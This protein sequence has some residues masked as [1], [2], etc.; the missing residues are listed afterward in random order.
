[1]N[2]NLYSRTNISILCFCIT[3]LVV[4]DIHA[5]NRSY[6]GF[7]NNP[8]NPSWG[9]KGAQ[10]R[11]I[12]PVSYG[13]GISAPN[14]VDRPNPRRISNILFDQEEAIFDNHALTDYVWVFGQFVEHDISFIGRDEAEPLSINV[15]ECDPVFDPNCQGQAIIPMA[16]S[17][18]IAGSGMSETNPRAYA[19]EVSAFLDGSAIYGSDSERA[20]WLRTFKDGKLKTSTGG[21]LPYNTID[22]E[23]NSATDNSAPEMKLNSSG[24]RRWFVAGDIR[25]NENMMLTSMHTLWVREHNR[26]CQVMS[27]RNPAM[28][29][30]ELYQKARKMVGAMIQ[31]ITYGEWLPAM[32]VTLDPYVSYW[33]D[34]DPNVSNVF[35]A[36]ASRFLHTLLSEELLRMDDGCTTIPAGDMSLRESFF[37]PVLVTESGIDPMLKG[38]SA[39]I[40]QALDCKLVD[41]IRNFIIESAESNL[42]CDF[43]AININRGRERG[44]PDYNTVR[45][46]LG[47]GRVRS[48]EEIVEDPVEARQLADLYGTVDNIDPWVGMLAEEHLPGAMFGETIMNIMKGQFKVLRDAD[49][50]F[51][52]NDDGLTQD[53]KDEVSSTRLSDVIRRNTSITALQEN[54]FVMEKHCDI[55]PVDEQHL[56]LAIAPNPVV[57]DYQFSMYSFEEGDGVLRVQNML[58]QLIQEYELPV[59]RGTNTYDL[60]FPDSAPMGIYTLTFKVG[61]ETSTLK[62]SRI[63]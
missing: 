19:N 47:L 60:R 17:R 15:P 36:A 5:Q 42:G 50:F 56:N 52:L 24:A 16:R 29:D 18:A 3:Y 34:I 46:A 63:Y 44:L 10:I 31:Q 27:I 8:S 12:T 58:G 38:M 37:N 32:G 41:D 9:A 35:S 4:F 61:R 43:A 25:A 45:D 59:S 48:F 51:F 6:D 40:Q 54:V 20:S 11:N 28:T 21:F 62:V 57:S 1:M 2:I 33:E 53:E 23:L 30:E 49:R 26:I 55:D 7:G 13:D 39:Q 22:G 14:G